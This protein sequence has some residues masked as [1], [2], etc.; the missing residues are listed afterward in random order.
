MRKFFVIL[1][2]LVVTVAITV[3]AFDGF[4]RGIWETIGMNTERQAQNVKSNNMDARQIAPIWVY[5]RMED[6]FSWV[7]KLGDADVT[8]TDSSSAWV[9]AGVDTTPVGL[10]GA[11]NPG[12]MRSSHFLWTEAFYS[13][14]LE[15]DQISTVE[16]KFTNVPKGEYQINLSIPSNLTIN[17]NNAYT[18]CN[19]AR[20]LV[21]VNDGLEVPVQVN[22]SRDAYSGKWIYVSDDTWVA[23]KADSFISVKVTNIGT[24]MLSASEEGE[25]TT[26]GTPIVLAD[27]VRLVQLSN[28]QTVGS[29]VSARANSGYIIKDDF[30]ARYDNQTWSAVQIGSAYSNKGEVALAPGEIA[31]N[32]QVLYSPSG[33]GAAAYDIIVPKTGK[34]TFKFNIPKIAGTRFV[35]AANETFY[36]YDYNN[37]LM[38]DYT[39]VGAGGGWRQ[40]T[41]NTFYLE[42]GKTYTIKTDANCLGYVLDAVKVELDTYTD[43]GN[44]FKYAGYPVVYTALNEDVSENSGYTGIEFLG[45]FAAVNATGDDGNEVAKEIWRYPSA[46]FNTWGPLEG[47]VAGGFAT[48]PLLVRMKDSK[49]EKDLMATFIGDKNGIFYAFD[50]SGGNESK[51][52]Q[53]RLLFKGPGIFKSEPL[54]PVTGWAQ[55][56]VSAAAFGGRYLYAS[57]PN[58]DPI[59]FSISESERYSIGDGDEY[60]AKGNV[61]STNF[62]Y[63]IKLWIPS[64]AL[65]AGSKINV[66]VEHGLTPMRSSYNVDISSADL[67][68]WKNIDDVDTFNR[69]L[70]VSVKPVTGVCVVDNV[71]FAPALPQD[72]EYAFGEPAFVTDTLIS[73]EGSAL[74][75]LQKPTKVFAVT[76]EGRVWAFDITSIFN[77]EN[78]T[79]KLAWVFPKLDEKFYYK[80]N[81][82]PTWNNKYLYIAGKTSALGNTW[83]IRAVWDTRSMDSGYHDDDLTNFKF[84]S[85]PYIGEILAGAMSQVKSYSDPTKTYMW[86]NTPNNTVEQYALDPVTNLFVLSNTVNLGTNPTRAYPSILSMK[87]NSLGYAE[88]ADRY[89]VFP[90]YL[91]NLYSLNAVSASPYTGYPKTGDIT[92]YGSFAADLYDNSVVVED[93][94]TGTSTLVKTPVPQGFLGYTDG[95]MKA[96]D[97]TSGSVLNTLLAGVPKDDTRNQIKSMPQILHWADKSG[98]SLVNINGGDGYNWA[99]SDKVYNGSFQGDKP[100]ADDWVEIVNAVDEIDP[101]DVSDTRADVQ[102]DFLTYEAAKDMLK[103]VDSSTNTA[104]IAD[105]TKS[106][107][108]NWVSDADIK[109][110]MVTKNMK[111]IKTQ[112]W[113]YI[114]TDNPLEPTADNML[115]TNERLFKYRLYMMRE[116]MKTRKSI[117]VAGNPISDRA[118]G[119]PLFWNDEQLSA[120]QPSKDLGARFEWG[121]RVY[122]ALW[123]MNS[124]VNFSG[125]RSFVFMNGDATRR[126]PA[127]LVKMWTVSYNVLYDDGTGTYK[128]V[129]DSAGNNIVN[130]YVLAEIKLDFGA[131]KIPTMVGSGWRLV[132]ELSGTGGDIYRLPVPRLRKT[133]TLLSFDNYLKETGDWIVTRGRVANST[134]ITRSEKI[135]FNNPL[136]VKLETTSGNKVLGPTYERY[137]ED[138]LFNGLPSGKVVSDY[139]IDFGKYTHGN[140]TPLK[141]IAKVANRAVANIDGVR[142]N[143]YGHQPEVSSFYSEKFPW[144]Y[145]VGSVDYPAISKE[146]VSV[147][148][149]ENF[150]MSTTGTTLNSKYGWNTEEDD[151]Y[152]KD[153]K[154]AKDVEDSTYTN[155]RY[156]IDIPRY[157]PA[158][159]KYVANAV[160]YIDVNG[161]GKFN[162][163]GSL[164]TADVN[165]EPYRAFQIIL[166]VTPDANI[167]VDSDAIDFGDAAH[168][169]GFP[170][171]LNGIYYPFYD[172]ILGYQ[173][174]VNYALGAKK[175]E[176]SRWFQP[177]KVINEGNVNLF[178]LQVDKQPLFASKMDSSFNMFNEGVKSSSRYDG[179]WSNA[180]RIHENNIISSL[181]SISSSIYTDKTSKDL[182][183]I[184][185][186]ASNR[187]ALNSKNTAGATFTLSKARVG[188][189]EDS[190]LT[191]PDMKKIKGRE[192]SKYNDY[193][194]KTDTAM[195]L[196]IRDVQEPLISLQVPLGMPVGEYATKY[197][198]RVSGTYY[199]NAD[200]K[201][202]T[203][204]SAD[205]LYLNVNV[206]EAQITGMPYDRKSSLASLYHIGGTYPDGV[207]RDYFLFDKYSDSTPFAYQVAN[208]KIGMVWSSNA[209]ALSSINSGASDDVASLAPSNISIGYMKDE[210]DVETTVSNIG[211]ESNYYSR[212][213]WW[214][215]GDMLLDSNGWPNDLLLTS[216]LPN[217]QVPNWEG[218]TNFKRVRMSNPSYYSYD[219]TSEWLTFAGRADI[220]D[221]AGGLIPGLTENRIFYLDCTGFDAGSINAG[222]AL[223]LDHLDATSEKKYPV[224]TSFDNNKKWF[225]WQSTQAGKSS[226][227]FTTNDFT[228]VSGN[229]LS[230]RFYDNN[231]LQGYSFE[232]KL[233]LP[234]AIASAGKPN[235]MTFIDNNNTRKMDL[236]YTGVNAVT[237]RTDVYLTRYTPSFNDNGISG[238]T[239]SATPLP[240]VFEE[241]TRDS[242]FE[243]FMSK[244]LAWIRQNRNG[245]IPKTDLPAVVIGI[246]WNA[247]DKI[248][249]KYIDI[250]SGSTVAFNMDDWKNNVV[251]NL[252]VF[253]N[254]LP[255]SGSSYPLFSFDAATNVMTIEYEPGSEANEELGKTLVDFSSGVIRFTRLK[256]REEYGYSQSEGNSVVYNKPVTVYAS[257]VPQTLNLT[258]GSGI[259]DGGYAFWDSTFKV[260]TVMWRKT[261]ADSANGIYFKVFE[262][263]TDSSA[264]DRTGFVALTEDKKVSSNSSD[265]SVN[266]NSVSGFYDRRTGGAYGKLWIF[267]A[268]TKS[269]TSSVYYATEAIN[270]K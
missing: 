9:S 53:H 129:L 267:W 17:S 240:R 103:I 243:F 76:A 174:G 55:S 81:T 161:N 5:P 179:D 207:T 94:T 144:E 28:L 59:K 186:F 146:S 194:Q 117:D 10:D 107:I 158:I 46:D 2:I 164:D 233:R 90:D 77:T 184:Y 128:N 134:A 69:V 123:N 191:I 200:D 252:P 165:D 175:P 120:R 60:D 52:S 111:V 40:F 182:S 153:R 235:V 110:G 84:I 137:G 108:D 223:S 95:Y 177:F 224:M 259:N 66:A 50:A 216:S 245:D 138:N 79:G 260:M 189:T 193:N 54:S 197:P 125:A 115:S 199:D 93:T 65:Y 1:A 269:G 34:Y 98:N 226:I 238:L 131:N 32:N 62:K 220:A 31:Y 72:E 61:L 234:S 27:A 256:D 42:S 251:N 237:G 159:K 126:I 21:K 97:L 86:V 127:S 239:E 135:A 264:S 254:L 244:G 236:V 212:M 92:S 85:T 109:N 113:N 101:S 44:T 87:L 270:L 91:S 35:Q 201:N 47:P 246:G 257:Y 133:D 41:D 145:G 156:Q 166:A 250:F 141:N 18:V 229:E 266:E 82:T 14:D 45:R 121:D 20:I 231:T 139:V 162:K 15:E 24:Y 140:F 49:G 258:M 227:S 209:L 78:K 30:Q 56:D 217:V 12:D 210:A 151:P 6:G 118:V 222:N 99:Y 63:R 218:N 58:V 255:K 180:L 241:M 48:S 119:R 64:V 232:N 116:A 172:R 173:G 4:P 214:N 142:Y 124:N 132:A 71:W 74:F 176:I 213:N 143:P 221:S 169:V 102:F 75:D 16:Y 37:V 163:T 242:K 152:L 203:V 262:E 247:A 57:N 83:D 100:F 106:G 73:P 150:D 70:S 96:Y 206:K 23:E 148:N 26:V 170:L 225:F 155:V 154:T 167:V 130:K 202:V 67:G 190:V 160:V 195:A 43:G 22:M 7:K 181:D 13:A 51:T 249:N 68:T 29:P 208:G 228:T 183:L 187:Q 3:Y 105:D 192:F 38:G 136:S 25:G 198:V 171:A 33:A 149:S 89:V 80:S 263:F 230:Q 219:G 157:Q 19:Q 248:Y 168:G 188:D 88:D 196:D 8:V 112:D 104:K 39:F 265:V 205:G 211:D 178:D 11:V 215:N 114:M 268:G 147:F 253:E 36:L 204:T 122:V 185:P 261:G